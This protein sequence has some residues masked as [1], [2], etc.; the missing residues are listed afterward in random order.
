MLTGGGVVHGA[1]ALEWFGNERGCGILNSM[2]Q[3]GQDTYNGV[4]YTPDVWGS[5][6]LN[7]VIVNVENQD[8]R[9]PVEAMVILSGEC[10]LANCPGRLGSR[11]SQ[12]I[13]KTGPYQ[14]VLLLSH[15]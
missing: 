14:F 1:P 10:I 15:Q 9:E 2:C 3:F 7:I 6:A 4:I 12:P 8:N 5:L 13:L 11:L